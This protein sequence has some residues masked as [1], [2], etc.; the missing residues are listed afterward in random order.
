MRLRLSRQLL[1]VNL[2]EALVLALGSTAGPGAAG[3]APSA[4]RGLLGAVGLGALPLVWLGVAHLA[5]SRNSPALE[6]AA[7]L[8][9]S[10]LLAWPVGGVQEGEWAPGAVM[11]GGVQHANVPTVLYYRRIHPACALSTLHWCAAVLPQCLYMH[12]STP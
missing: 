7:T 6:Q 2:T 3:V 10:I 12:G 11:L 9:F 8:G 1:L 4:Q 5:V